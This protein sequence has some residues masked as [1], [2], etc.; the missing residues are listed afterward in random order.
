MAQGAGSTTGQAPRFLSPE[1]PGRAGIRPAQTTGSL[2]LTAGSLPRQPAEVK[3]V[4]GGP[5]RRV[6]GCY[7]SAEG[8]EGGDREAAAGV[9]D[10][11][12]GGSGAARGAG[13]AA[14]RAAGR[15]R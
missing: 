11:A 7:L 14:A 5:G 8:V 2:R 1:E 3:P 9:H 12:A 10:R 13:G 6:A 4:D 15:T